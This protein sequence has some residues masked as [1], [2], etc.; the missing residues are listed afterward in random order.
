MYTSCMAV[1][2]LYLLLPLASDL[3]L[4][5]VSLASLVP[6]VVPPHHSWSCVPIPAFCIAKLQTSCSYNLTLQN[7]ES[8]NSGPFLATGSYFPMVHYIA[9]RQYCV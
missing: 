6:P 4:S 7:S 1:S 8:A 5:A 3:T 2:V 9:L